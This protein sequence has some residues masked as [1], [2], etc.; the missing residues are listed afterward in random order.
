MDRPNELLANRP[1]ISN[2]HLRKQPACS[3]CLFDR[4]KPRRLLDMLWVIVLKVAG[5][6]E[7]RSGHKNA[8]AP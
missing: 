5:C 7:K 6:S 4:H 2:A 8:L 3:D 1:G